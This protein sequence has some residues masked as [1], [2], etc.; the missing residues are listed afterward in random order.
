MLRV[1]VNT[2]KTVLGELVARLRSLRFLIAVE[3]V[4]K[5]AQVDVD[6]TR[7]ASFGQ[8]VKCE[9]EV[10]KIQ[11]VT[12]MGICG[13]VSCAGC[14]KQL[15]SEPVCPEKDC[16]ATAN[17]Y[18]IHCGVDLFRS[19]EIDVQFGSK[20]DAII[21]LVRQFEPQDQFLL[22]VQWEELGINIQ[23]ALENKKIKVW[24]LLKSTDTK[25]KSAMQKFQ[26]TLYDPKGKNKDWKQGLILCSSNADAAGA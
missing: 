15:R 23:K 11:D 1:Q 24:S 16:R 7:N 14:A 3:N 18:Q 2:I 22:F 6:A 9:K 25:K 10:R 4:Q 20:T 21:R 5:V 17:Y 12:V 19:N 13:H 8:C 26:D